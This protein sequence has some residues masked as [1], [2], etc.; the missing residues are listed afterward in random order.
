[1]KEAIE[2]IT[3]YMIES[4]NCV[5]RLVYIAFSSRILSNYRASKGTFTLERNHILNYSLWLDHDSL[6][7]L[8]LSSI[9]N[10]SVKIIIYK[11]IEKYNVTSDAIYRLT[12]TCSYIIYQI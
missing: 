6:S 4:R 2:K 12:K 10:P 7:D 5:S 9:D 8:L 1:M 3:E 11:H